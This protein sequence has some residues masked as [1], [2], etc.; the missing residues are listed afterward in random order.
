MRYAREDLLILKYIIQCKTNW[1]DN[2]QVPMFGDLVYSATY[3]KSGVSVGN[4]GYLIMD[5]NWF[6]YSFVTV[7][8]VK[9]EKIK[10]NS[11]CV[12]RVRYLSEGNY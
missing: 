5:V 4:N 9:L 3:F 7:P 12:L 8:R 10:E 11:V 6:T 1:N 2:A